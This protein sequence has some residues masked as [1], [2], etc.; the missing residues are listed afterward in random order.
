MSD[1][2]KIYYILKAIEEIKQE[3]RDAHVRHE[4]AVSEMQSLLRTHMDKEDTVME[5][6]FEKVHRTQ[7]DITKLQHQAGRWDAT[8]SRMWA[9][10]IPLAVTLAANAVLAL[11]LL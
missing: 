10:I 9:F 3:Q 4:Q 8:S 1:E 5:N 11:G 2:S 7:L 6:I